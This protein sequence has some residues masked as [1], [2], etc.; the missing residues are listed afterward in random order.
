MVLLSGWAVRNEESSDQR[1]R[2]L[3]GHNLAQK[4]FEKVWKAVW[5][6]VW[7]TVR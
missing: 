2:Q 4:Q 5:V 1:G 6:L 7:Q 3:Q